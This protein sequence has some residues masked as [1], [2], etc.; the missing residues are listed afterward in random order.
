M[1]RDALAAIQFEWH[2]GDQGV[3][4]ESALDRHPQQSLVLTS[5]LPT[6]ATGAALRE[7]LPLA[8]CATAHEAHDGSEVADG[9]RDLCDGVA[10]GAGVIRVRWR[11]GKA[12]PKV[13]EVAKE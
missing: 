2:R 8:S 5:P 1:S 12:A 11:L 10:G 7:L 13:R 6:T 3:V 9:P 4:L